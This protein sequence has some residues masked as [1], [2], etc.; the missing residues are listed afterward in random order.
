MTHFKYEEKFN[1]PVVTLNFR[2]IFFFFLRNNKITNGK[3]I[4]LTS[5]YMVI[6]NMFV[7]N[8]LIA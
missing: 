5:Y 7:L 6:S 1:S 4:K 8:K 2:K 3:Y